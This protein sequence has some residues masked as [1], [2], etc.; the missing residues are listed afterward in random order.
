MS[1]STRLQHFLQRFG[2]SKQNFISFK[3]SYPIERTLQS[4]KRIY[5]KVHTEKLI[6]ATTAHKRGSKRVVRAAK[7]VKG[8]HHDTFRAVAALIRF[9]L[10]KSGGKYEQYRRIH[11]AMSQGKETYGV[12]SAQYPVEK[13]VKDLAHAIYNHSELLTNSP[14]WVLNYRKGRLKI[15]GDT[16]ALPS[17]QITLSQIDP[18]GYA[19][20]EEVEA[21]IK[22]TLA[23]VG[24]TSTHIAVRKRG[25]INEIHSIA[26]YVYFASA[27][28]A[29]AAINTLKVLGRVSLGQ[30][31]VTARV[32]ASK[33]KQAIQLLLSEADG[34]LAQQRSPKAM[35]QLKSIK[36][37]LDLQEWID[38]DGN[39]TFIKLKIVDRSYHIFK[40]GES[41]VTYLLEY[42]GNEGE[43][44]RFYPALV[45]QFAVS[46]DFMYHLPNG[47]PV[48]VKL[49]LSSA[50]HLAAW[51]KAGRS[52]GHEQRDLYSDHSRASMYH[53]IAYQDKPNFTYS[54]HVVT[55]RTI[56]HEQQKW[57]SNQV[58][59]GTITTQKQVQEHLGQLYRIHGRVERTPA[60]MNGETKVQPNVYES[61]LITPLVLHNQSYCCLTTLN[62]GL[63]HIVT[64]DSANL[65][66]LQRRLSGLKDGIG[67]TKCATSGTGI[68]NLINDCL[69]LES[70]TRSSFSKYAPIWYLMDTICHHLKLKGKTKDGK[71]VALLKHERLCFTSFTFIWWLLI[72][73][74]S[75]DTGGR[76]LKRGN[77]NH[78]QDKI[79]PYEL[80]NACP[81]WEEHI[82]IPLSLIDESLFEG[83]FS[84]RMINATRSKV[85]N[86]AERKISAFTDMCNKIAPKKKRAASIMSGLPDHIRR[87]MIIRPCWRCSTKWHFNIRA[88]LLNRIATYDYHHRV[89]F[90]KDGTIHFNVKGQIDPFHSTRL[91]V[92]NLI[93][94]PCGK[95]H[96]LPTTNI[97]PKS[98]K[99][100]HFC[101]RKTRTI[102]LHTLSRSYQGRLL[103]CHI[104][105]AKHFHAQLKA[106]L[107][108][109][110]AQRDAIETKDLTDRYN[111]YQGLHPQQ[112]QPIRMTRPLKKLLKEAE[113]KVKQPKD[114]WDGDLAAIPLDLRRL[115][116]DREWTVERLKSILRFFQLHGMRGPSTKLSGKKCEVVDRV[117]PLIMQRRV[118][119]TAPDDS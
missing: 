59:A 25:H 29:R 65:K 18:N 107:R 115:N 40:K 94:D 4:A 27:Y 63:K 62:M 86:E 82:Q 79:Y 28:E 48:R 72:G 49:T 22:D 34:R 85:G 33:V 67:I 69:S 92:P 55:H 88:G 108:L 19:T 47:Q 42:V 12:T 30:T 52:G 21:T 61:L 76:Q 81:E 57:I 35:E 98:L 83:T 13:Q 77:K 56:I 75:D 45:D 51:A 106:I 89:T 74:L 103:Q 24:L 5:Y 16:L 2:E 66:K 64:D 11:R 31:I 97:F 99:I 109:P 70:D 101:F 60:L 20:E 105:R 44:R 3:K 104:K 6:S 102:T 87:N 119:Q 91:A 95:C 78:L 17:D 39:V 8:W 73:D 1:Q 96:K 117:V 38:K 113:T 26:A 58:A 54:R 93:I 43:C 53:L 116:T 50:D 118:M 110:V 84:F 46:N 15:A 7:R 68:R 90:A 100:W 112:L 80:A 9:G 23:T 32:V 111:L 37:M 114:I 10:L 36:I 71:H 14:D 41:R